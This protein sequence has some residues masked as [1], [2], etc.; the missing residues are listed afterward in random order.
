MFVPRGPTGGAPDTSSLGAPTVVVI[1]VLLFGGT[2][3]LWQTRYIRP[4]TAYALLVVY[5]LGIAAIA[6]WSYRHPM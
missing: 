3:Y 5:L 6:L 2:V 1:L 4:K